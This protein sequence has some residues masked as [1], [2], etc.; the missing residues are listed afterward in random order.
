MIAEADIAAARVRWDVIAADVPLKR[1]GRELVGCCPFHAEKTPSF[2]VAPDKGFFH[3]FGCGA[4]GTVVDYVMRVR[5]LKF[6][7]AVTE[8]LGLPAQRAKEAAP[9]AVVRNHRTTDDDDDRAERVLEV[10]AGCGPVAVG[11]AAYLYLTLRG[12]RPE[13][14]ALLAH[15]AL[16]CHEV[17]GPQPALVA[18]LTNSAGEVCAVQRIWCLPRIEY[19]NGSGPRDSRAPLKVRKKTLG[20]MGDAA[21]RLKL[22]VG[23]MLGLAEGVESALAAIRLF[24]IPVWAVCGAAR[25]GHVWIPP[26]VPE[27]LIFGDNGDTGHDLA[28]RA[29]DLHLARGLTCSP[30]FPDA[31]YGDFADQLIGWRS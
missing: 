10:L 19:V 14:P 13:Q 26:G 15:Q 31:D 9:S 30:V 16:Y 29:V 6:P 25:L 2:T 22:A 12:L 5:G 4:H 18:P 27:L 23:P 28:E 20:H 24:R 11:T 8:I 21:V 7:E 1:N 17:G 3:C